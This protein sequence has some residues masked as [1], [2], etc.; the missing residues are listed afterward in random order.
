MS[1]LRMV[2]CE[3]VLVWDEEQRL[4]GRGAYVHPD[5]G[6]I[7]RMGQAARWERALRISQGILNVE[8][9][10]LTVVRLMDRVTKEQ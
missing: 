2:L 10:R 8:Q 9:L 3:G 6:C 4:P 7:S 1:L 5:I